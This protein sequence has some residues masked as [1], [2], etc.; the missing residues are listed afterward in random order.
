MIYS[1]NFANYPVCR[2]GNSGD[3]NGVCIDIASH[4]AYPSLVTH[5]VKVKQRSG[6]DY[7]LRLI[8]SRLGCGY[9]SS[10]FV[11]V[12][13]DLLAER[14]VLAMDFLL[15]MSQDDLTELSRRQTCGLVSRFNAVTFQVEIS[16]ND[17]RAKCSRHLRESRIQYGPKAFCTHTVCR[18]SSFW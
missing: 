5:R 2:P 17:P 10:A 16:L 7:P 4:V 18:R 6:Q 12:I 8:P 3:I 1:N 9:Q 13:V 15:Q 14:R 11:G